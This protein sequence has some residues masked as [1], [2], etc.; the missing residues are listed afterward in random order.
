MA[1][2]FLIASPFTYHGDL[3]EKTDQ[4]LEELGFYRGYSCAHNHVIRNKQDHWC[5]ECVHKIVSNVCGFD[6]NYLHASYKH[7]YSSLWNSVQMHSF[8]ECWTLKNKKSKSSKRI[9]L[10]SYRSGYSKQCAENVTVHKAIYQCA[11]GD[12]GSLSVTRTC[13]NKECCNP[14]HFTSQ[15]NR[16]TPPR[17]IAPF[18]IKFKAEKLMFYAEQQERGTLKNFLRSQ[19]KL[20]IAKPSLVKE[21]EQ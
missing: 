18:D 15:F 4:E 14:L 19:Y 6:V 2:P 8:S 17:S 7:K 5:Y 12:V 11:W 1:N 9:C 21:P 20:S 10:P 3:N 16:L 13:G